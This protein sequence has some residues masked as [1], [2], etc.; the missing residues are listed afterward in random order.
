[1]TVVREISKHKLHLVGVQEVKW[2]TGDTE[3][4]GKYKFFYGKG[5]ENHQ[6]GTGFFH[7]QSTLDYPGAD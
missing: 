5:N 2:E 7:I 3:P 4:S 1:M 6:L